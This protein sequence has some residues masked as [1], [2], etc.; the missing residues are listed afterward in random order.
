VVS[1]GWGRLTTT[2]RIYD[3]CEGVRTTVEHIIS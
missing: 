3:I 2:P 1:F